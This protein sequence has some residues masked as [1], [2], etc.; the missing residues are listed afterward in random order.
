MIWTGSRK[1]HKTS[2]Y[3]GEHEDVD[4][5]DFE[6]ETGSRSKRLR[7]EIVAVAEEESMPTNMVCCDVSILY[8]CFVTQLVPLNVCNEGC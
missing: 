8:S 1:S 2:V 3:F 7:E 5:F 4:G 6:M